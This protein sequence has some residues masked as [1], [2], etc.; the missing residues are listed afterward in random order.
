MLNTAH[1]SL[2]QAPPISIPFR[3]FLT[4]PLFG[5]AAGLVL[6]WVGEAAMV[7]RWNPV[8]LGLTHL[9]ALGFL[10]MVMCGAMIQMLPVLAGSP[11][12]GVR[13][14][15]TV[16]HLALSLGTGA[17][18]YAFLQG[19]SGWM[20]LALL[21]LSIG[22]GFFVVAVGLALARVRLSSPTVTGMRWSLVSLMITVLLGM[23]LSMGLF[24]FVALNNLAAYT[25]LHLGWG[26]LG[27]MGLLLISV[28]YQVVPMFQV[29]PEYPKLMRDFLTRSLFFGLV[30]WFLLEIGVIQGYWSTL[31]PA[32]WILLLTAGFPL[33][34][35]MTLRIQR[36]RKRQVSDVTLFFWRVGL[37]GILF[38]YLVWLIG[39]ALPEAAAAPWYPLLL[40]VLLLFGGAFPLVNGMLYKIVPFLSWFHLQ[41]R[42]LALGAFQV[43]LPHMKGFI[44]DREARLQFYLYLAALFL[45]L[46]AVFRP[47]L[48][49]RPAGAFLVLTSLMLGYNLLRAVMRY[50]NTKVLLNQT[51]SH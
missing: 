28:S 42:Q 50:R 37:I 27:W 10:S 6:I 39:R 30:G 15:G 43:K 41:N 25:D 9:I 21:L 5:I 40:G 4:A 17:L 20:K 22:F 7:S 16:S 38:G 2:E 49:T 11:V 44:G 24:G 13:P 12:P 47:A 35:G 48:F 18:V 32:C 23:L 19:S 14:V 33:F 46:A 1:L 45:A 51:E 29:T 3:F 8:A 31:I 34:A 26:L 36:L